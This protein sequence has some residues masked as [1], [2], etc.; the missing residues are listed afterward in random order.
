MTAATML[1]GYG[2]AA[3]KSALWQRYERWAAAWDGRES[4][5]DLTFAEQTGD[6]I[7]QLGLGQNLVQ[8]ITTARSWLSDKETLQRLSQLTRVKR[9]R[10]QLDEDLKIWENQPLVISFNHNPPP[11]GLD[12]GVAQYEFHSINELEDK[13]N[14]FPAGTKFVLGIP[15]VNSP[16]NEESRK[17]LRNFLASH[18]MIVAAERRIE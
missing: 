2:S 4:E 17:E 12:A 1:G 16:A 3:V 10:N 15:P 14:Q 5:L 9:V 18:G 6:Q 11:L 8:A 7:Y 13:L